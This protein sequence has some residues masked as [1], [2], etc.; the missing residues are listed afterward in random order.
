MPLFSRTRGRKILSFLL[1]SLLF[2]LAY[3]QPRLYYSNQHQYFLHGAAAAGEGFLSHDWLAN[4]ADP[5]PVFS[6]LVAWTLRYGHS[7]LFYGYYLII[8]GIYL[9]ALMGI[10]D[11]LGDSLQSPSPPVHR[12]RGVGVKGWT[13]SRIFA[14]S[15]PL[16][17]IEG[18][19]ERTDS[20]QSRE[21]AKR[22]RWAFLT[23]VVVVHSGL[24]RWSSV[25]VFGVDYP[26]YF[27]AGVANQYILGA[28][29]Q[30]SVF[31]VW[32]V[33]SVS[34]FLKNRPYLAV[35]WAALSGVIHST[36]LLSAALLTLSYLYLLLRAG[37]R[38][39]AALVGL[40]ALLVVSPVVVYNAVSFA[41]SSPQAFAEA[42]HLLAHV[43]IPH[44][45]QV[46]RWLDGLAWMQLG[47]ILCAM[48]LVR[49]SR[50]FVVLSVC[51]VGSLA[52]TLVQVAT[53]NDTLA[54]LFPWRTSSFLVPIATAVILTQTLNHF[55][56]RS[57]P[58]IQ[59]IY[60]FVLIVFVTGGVVISYFGLGYRTNTQETRLLEYIRDHKTAE[61]VY[62]LPVELPKLTSGQRGAASLNFTPPP[63]RSTQKQNISVDL[64]QFRLFTG[65]PIYIDFKSIPYKDVEVLEW[66]HR[67]LWTHGLYEER[68]W[69]EHEI[70]TELSRRKITHIVATADRDISCAALELVCKDPSYRLYRVRK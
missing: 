23:F 53:G 1:G 6:T 26:W 30:P 25:R 44:H 12:G 14:P 47:W 22:A 69:N 36:Y 8:L 28:G 9:H 34:I 41:P 65:A 39:D 67:V 57:Y 5:T 15:T 56:F 42:Q 50:L 68:N 45:T 66:R 18:G 37:R 21:S 63:Q 59:Y 16:P 52:L 70:A 62:L 3:T 38:R 48:F 64:Q 51:F 32:L 24:L 10:F 55:A 54:L 43:R 27:Q 40:W 33:L 60:G 20:Q 4:T 49:K 31:G 2:G 19:G 11:A 46:D 17:R 35:T 61:D 29:L 7:F 58:A 13:F